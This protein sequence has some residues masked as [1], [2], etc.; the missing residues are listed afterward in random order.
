MDQED[1]DAMLEAFLD[2]LKNGIEDAM[3]EQ[4]PNFYGDT[5]EAQ[6]RA[7]R[8]AGYHLGSNAKL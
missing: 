1:K 5:T 3:M 7:A 2:G 4:W 8:S 6:V